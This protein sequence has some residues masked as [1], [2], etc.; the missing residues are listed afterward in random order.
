MTKPPRRGE[1]WFVSLN[2]TVGHEQAGRR[3]AV[4]ISED[5]FNSGPADLVVLLPITSTLKPIPSQIRL[6]PPEGGLDRES[7]VL[8]EAVRSVSRQRLI[9][10][11]GAVSAARLALVE[12]ALRILLR[13]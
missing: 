4:V 5:A 1:V 13:L 6:S 3:P 11:L 7:A 9:R 12:D 2:P 8:C 10:R